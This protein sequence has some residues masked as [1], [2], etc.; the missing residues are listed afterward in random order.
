MLKV[1]NS[2]A[3]IESHYK[4]FNYA[5]VLKKLSLFHLKTELFLLDA[6]GIC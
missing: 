5:F 2:F 3:I 1:I 4:N 6:C